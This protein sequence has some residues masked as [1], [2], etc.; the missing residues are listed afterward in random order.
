MNV[1][2]ERTGKP[3]T[4]G[5]RPRRPLRR[6]LVAAVAASALLLTGCAPLVG[7]LQELTAEVPG[8]ASDF[9]SFD[10]QQ[11]RWV[12]CEN[13][14][15]CARVYAPLDWEQPDG[16]RI[17]LALV[18]QP[19]LSGDALGTI[20]VNPGGPGAP[21]V[22][23]LRSNIDGAVSRDLQERFDIVGWDP[24]GTGESSAVRCLDAA[25]M[26][27]FLFG[28]GEAAGRERGSD[29]WLDAAEAESAAFGEACLGATGPLLAH[30]DTMS[31][32]RDLDMLRA[33][34]GDEQLNYLGYSYGTYIGAR[35]A[36][37]YPERVGRMVLDGA[38]D[39]STSEA[40]VVREQT[41]GFEASLRAYAADCLT[42]EGC[43]LSGSVD[44]AMRQIGA[45]LDQVDRQ[46][47]AANDG[48]VL[49]TDTMLT[50]IITPLYAQVNWPYLDDLFA[51]VARGEAETAFFL[52]DYYFDRVDGK[53]QTNLTE[54]FLAINCL[55]YPSERPLDRERLRAEAAELAAIAPTIGRY[56]GYGDVLCANW[57][58]RGVETR[59]PVRAEGSEP[60]LV[61]GT[62]GDPATPYRWA[63][64]L[65]EQLQNG[66]LVTYHGE[67]H[68]AY[69]EHPCVTAVI[70]AY[71][72]TGEAPASDPNCAA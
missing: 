65:A 10:A 4:R 17:T 8:P 53:Y 63:V 40:D 7:V 42:R 71:F 47:I 18:R 55:D 16:D 72:L 30:V 48:R 54:A 66:V 59:D 15:Q 39:P 43:P 29:A 6:G 69:G 50:A 19:A 70:D 12:D 9:A 25:G 62:T 36:D 13:G 58:V 67:G 57:P 37:R 5:A 46:P 35:Y 61:V 14:M 28:Q 2:E 26:D 68:T 34:V 24:R 45:L 23:Y 44:D 60:I 32:V 41:R 22:S 1:T 49:S 3:E 11:P 52:A 33:I 56:Q 31:T 64:A 20:F 51:E 38:T 27:E 21:G